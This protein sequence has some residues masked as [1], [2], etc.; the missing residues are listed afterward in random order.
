MDD[1]FRV[2]TIKEIKVFTINF[3]TRFPLVALDK[4]QMKAIHGWK[5]NQQN[6]CSFIIPLYTYC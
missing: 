5:K 2:Q 1:K 3:V 6:T 4:S